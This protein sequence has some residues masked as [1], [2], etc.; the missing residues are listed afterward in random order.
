M[1]SVRRRTVTACLK[2]VGEKLSYSVH[3]SSV[4]IA[5]LH[6]LHNV[7]MYLLT[8][9]THFSHVCHLIGATGESRKSDSC[10]DTK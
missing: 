3:R 1:N 6:R 4:A 5:T 9:C 7:F 2:Q 8:S 10:T